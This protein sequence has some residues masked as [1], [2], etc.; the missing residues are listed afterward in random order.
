MPKSELIDK[1]MSKV[2]IPDN[3]EYCWIW[4]AA[5]DRRGYGQFN[6]KLDGRWRAHRLSYTLFCSPIP[7]GHSV[8]HSCD[9]PSCV[10]PAHLWTGT[11]SDNMRDMV[12]KGRAKI[13]NMKL[14]KDSAEN[15]KVIMSNSIKFKDIESKFGITRHE[16]RNIRRGNG[17]IRG[18][19]L[20]DE[21][22]K[23]IEILL[24]QKI[25]QKDLA[26][27]F[28]VKPRLIRNIKSGKV[29]AYV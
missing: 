11:H 3:E 5:K 25:K 21:H 27:K 12:K 28:G 23:E 16:V 1:F 7:D 2:Q 4:T 9:N 24:S 15:I 13:P 17:K 14:T 8:C 29:W 20:S 19:K 26:K 22:L 6:S 18:S 10:N